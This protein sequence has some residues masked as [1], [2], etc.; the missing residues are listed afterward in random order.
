MANKNI[1]DY[2]QLGGIKRKEKCS[3]EVLKASASK[4]AQARWE[5]YRLRKSHQCS[6]IC[7]CWRCGRKKYQHSKYSENKCEFECQT[8]K[9]GTLDWQ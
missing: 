9:E 1:K 4:A 3:T 6:D 5:R 2:S 7:K 8:V